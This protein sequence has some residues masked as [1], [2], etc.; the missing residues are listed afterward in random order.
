LRQAATIA[1]RHVGGE[2]AGLAAFGGDDVDG[3]LRRL[4]VAVDAK[5]LCAL[6]RKG[7]RGR[8]AIAPA[9]PDRA[10]ADHHRCL[11]LESIHR[12]SPVMMLLIL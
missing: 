10:G 12:L 6:A 4:A 5:H 8:L 2:G 1:S 3:F 7:H 9:R 11:A